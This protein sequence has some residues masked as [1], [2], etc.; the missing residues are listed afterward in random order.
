VAGD[1]LLVRTGAL[2]AARTSGDWRGYRKGPA[3]GLA[4]A[5]AGWLYRREIGLVA[6][7][8]RAVE[9]QETGDDAR[10]LCEVS[11]E[12]SGVLF[13]LDFDLAPLARAC[14]ADGNYAFLW[15][16]P[17]LPGAGENPARP[18]AIK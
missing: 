9:V 4:L 7:D 2:C 3:P 5:C 6:C 18:V 14:A 17:P 10:P 11:L 12:H 16:A 13:G 15:V 8:T 1:L